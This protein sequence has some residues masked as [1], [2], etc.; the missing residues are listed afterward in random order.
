ML[1]RTVDQDREDKIEPSISPSLFDIHS[2]VINRKFNVR[3]AS[4]INATRREIRI[5]DNLFAFIFDIS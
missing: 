1:S 4:S 2:R 3:K 5:S